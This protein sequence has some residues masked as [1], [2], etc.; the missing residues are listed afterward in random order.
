MTSQPGKPTNI[1]EAVAEALGG[2][3]ATH[4]YQ[5][6]LNIGLLAD[7]VEGEVYSAAE[8]R[9]L[10]ATVM[11]LVDAVERQLGKVSADL[12]DEDEKTL[13]RT[14]QLTALL[15]AQAK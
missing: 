8:A 6:Y 12:K 15:R 10:L 11:D 2:L 5:T 4:L 9:K 3:T 1:P 14:R 7:A 13:E